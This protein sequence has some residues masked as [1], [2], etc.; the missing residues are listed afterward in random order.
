VLDPLARIHGRLVL[1][2]RMTVL[3][4][5]IT[6]MLQAKGSV[7]DVGCGNGVIS[8]LVM[9]SCHGIF[10]QGIDVLERPACAI[11]MQVFN[12][13]TFP[14]ADDS[15]DSVMFVDVLHHTT[16]PGQLLAE[17]AR[18]ARHWII[19]KDHLGNN[20]FSKGVLA[21]MDWVGNRPHGVNLPYNYL[22]SA[23]WDRCW[24]ALDSSPDIYLTKLGLYPGFVRPLFENGL[25]F[26]CRIE[27][28]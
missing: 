12:G 10:I 13:T 9:E 26:M 5:H 17:A 23:D 21:F 18:V 22:S 4:R 28:H 19:I 8:N 6:S 24:A 20:R 16:N 15:V 2:R 3:A 7:L 25:H 27:I 11:P 14:L 1:N